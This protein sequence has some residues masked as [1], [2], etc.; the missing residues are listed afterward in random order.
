MEYDTPNDEDKMYKL[1]LHVG[2]GM[3][4]CYVLI[5]SEMDGCYLLISSEMDG[6]YLLISS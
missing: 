3:D 4:G 5:S 6:C 1:L 2:P